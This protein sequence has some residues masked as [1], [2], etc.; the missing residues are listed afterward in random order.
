MPSIIPKAKDR[1]GESFQKC[2]CL[3]VS[4]VCLFCDIAATKSQ[5]SGFKVKVLLSSSQCAYGKACF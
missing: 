3:C 1:L 2:S 5:G 4:D